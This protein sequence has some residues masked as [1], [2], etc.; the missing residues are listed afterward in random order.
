MHIYKQ[1]NAGQRR[2]SDCLQMQVNT[3][4]IASISVLMLSLYVLVGLGHSEAI[5]ITAS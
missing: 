1:E 2:V 5:S 4:D 3:V